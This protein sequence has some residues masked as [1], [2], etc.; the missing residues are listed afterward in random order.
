MKP[1]WVV[2]DIGGVLFDWFASHREVAAFLGVSEGELQEKIS[3]LKESLQL[4]KI[5]AEDG[6]RKI[7]K[8]LGSKRSAEEVLTLWTDQKNLLPSSLQLLQDL[9]QAGYHLAIFSNTWS[10]LIELT[11]RGRPEI[12]LFDRVIAS[13]E[14]HLRKPEPAIYEYAEKEFGSSGDSIYLI[15]DEER[16]I[17]AAKERGWQ[18]F[19]YDIG[20]DRGKSSDDAI[21]KV[22]L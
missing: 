3:P 21:R 13:P 1:T 11:F 17:I 14:V 5:S 7:I 12:N 2:F 4:G 9:N 20:S 19:I 18:T 16:N 22:L 15:D 6:W 10:G 8:E